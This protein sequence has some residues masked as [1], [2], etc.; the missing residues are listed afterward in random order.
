[1]STSRQLART[2]LNGFHSM[3]ADFQNITLGAR[4]RFEQQDWT[5]VQQ[6]Q[7]DRL[8]IYKAKV[9]QLLPLLRNLAGDHIHNLTTWQKMRQ[10]YA[11]LI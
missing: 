2:I 9:D 3:F 11:Q 5:G 4:A 8:E 1:M 10:D 7:A 6:A